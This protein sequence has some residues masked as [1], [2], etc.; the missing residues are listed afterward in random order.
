MAYYKFNIDISIYRSNFDFNNEI[1]FNEDDEDEERYE[2]IYFISNNRN[3]F[4]GYKL[5]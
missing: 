5:Y 2:Y 3:S 4:N 1:N